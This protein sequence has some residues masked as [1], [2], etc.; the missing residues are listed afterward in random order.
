MD[1]DIIR[2]AHIILRN[3]EIDAMREIAR[4]AHER[5]NAQEVSI[6]RGGGLRRQGDLMGPDL[7]RVKDMLNKL[8]VVFGIDLPFDHEPSNK[9]N[10]T[11][12]PLLIT[13]IDIINPGSGYTS[14]PID[15]RKPKPEETR[16]DCT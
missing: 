6:L 1:I 10:G 5:L 14:A 8:G 16:S 15:P 4:L 9:P 12:F 3:N 11:G 13:S 2:N 7:F